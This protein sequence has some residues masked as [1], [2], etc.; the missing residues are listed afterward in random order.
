MA[1]RHISNEH[2]SVAVPELIVERTTSTLSNGLST[3]IIDTNSLIQS[4]HS[5]TDS[6]STSMNTSWANS[7]GSISDQT[8]Q[9]III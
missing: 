7:Y 3:Q 9:H 1:T 8:E 2:N 4:S 5:S 6:H